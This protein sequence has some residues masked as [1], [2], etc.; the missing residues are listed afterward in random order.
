MRTLNAWRAFQEGLT[1]TA[2]LIV[3]CDAI[4]SLT[5]SLQKQL[6]EKRL[7]AVNA[8]LDKYFS[9]ITGEENARARGLRVSAHETPKRMNYTVVDGSDDD[10]ISILNQADMNALSLAMLFAQVETE[11]KEGGLALVVLDDAEQS[12]DEKYVNG[13]AEAIEKI[14]AHR[15]VLIGAPPGPLQRRIR[16]FASCHK[17]FIPLSDWDPA[18]G[19]AIGPLDGSV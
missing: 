7:A 1:E 14:A 6:S 5:R 8:N 11:S 19:A 12:L 2:G 15:S 16:D 9:M 3:D 4:A 10:L 13:L 17:R 18:E